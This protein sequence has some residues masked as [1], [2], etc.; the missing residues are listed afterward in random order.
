MYFK[1]LL[2]GGVLFPKKVYLHYFLYV[3]AYS[4]VSQC[5][6]WCESKGGLRVPMILLLECLPRKELQ[7][8]CKPKLLP[9]LRFHVTFVYSYILQWFVDKEVSTV[10]CWRVV[11][12]A[13]RREWSR[14]TSWKAPWC[15]NW[16]ECWCISSYTKIFYQ[17]CLALS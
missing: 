2:G 6:E 9:F 4:K 12:E 11:V 1:M 15:F 7:N 10:L 13:C 8:V 16:W 14:S 5:P 17:W 3:C